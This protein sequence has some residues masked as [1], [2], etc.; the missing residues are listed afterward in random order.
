[1][2][3][4]KK[5]LNSMLDELLKIEVAD[6]RLKALENYWILHRLIELIEPKKGENKMN[7]HEHTS[8]NGIE[9][10]HEELNYIYDLFVLTNGMEQIADKK[11]HLTL[12]DKLAD[13]IITMNIRR[14][15]KEQ[16]ENE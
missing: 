12:S 6:I 15:K 8:M 4:Y 3:E 11:A 14:N 7:E 2:N 1:M 5:A 10:T 9:F 16:K 13:V